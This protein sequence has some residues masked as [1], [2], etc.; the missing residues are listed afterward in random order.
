MLNNHL[1]TINMRLI[2]AQS[3]ASIYQQKNK[4]ESYE[5][6]RGSSAAAPPPSAKRVEEGHQ[7]RGQEEE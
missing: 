1:L 6:R 4:N 2:K 5:K 7:S 3:S